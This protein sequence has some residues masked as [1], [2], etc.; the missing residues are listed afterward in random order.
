MPQI[1]S[2]LVENS[3][4]VCQ[5]LVSQIRLVKNAL[6][7]WFLIIPDSDKTEWFD[8][9]EK[10]QQDLNRQISQISRF[11]KEKQAADKINIAMIGNLVP[12]LHIHV[13]GRKQDDFCWPDVIWG[14]PEFQAYSIEAS[15][16]LIAKFNREVM[17]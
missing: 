11:I 13:I 2:R 3:Y 10:L 15:Q 9:D 16:Q 14:R 8:F 5:T 7:S 12:Q 6:V 17:L 1:D 4:F